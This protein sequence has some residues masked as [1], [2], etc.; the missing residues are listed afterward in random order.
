M[1]GFFVEK[2]CLAAFAHLR[3]LSVK[4][5][6]LLEAAAKSFTVGPVLTQLCSVS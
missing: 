2:A 4:G 3:V 1:E 5:L 6:S